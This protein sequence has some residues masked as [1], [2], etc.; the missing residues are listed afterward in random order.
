[1]DIDFIVPRV[2][3]LCCGALDMQGFARD[4]GFDVV[5]VDSVL[6][7]QMQAELD[8]YYARLYGLSRFELEFLLEPESIKPG[9][10]SETF[11][12]LKRNEEKAFGEYRTKRL[13]LEAWDK[14]EKG[15]LL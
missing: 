4:L 1:M 9:Y 3:R 15:E 5:E 13:V 14:L 12:V 11:S 7:A 10:P 2:A 8:A 6:R